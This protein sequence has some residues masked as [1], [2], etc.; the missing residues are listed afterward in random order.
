MI[1][2]LLD[3]DLIVFSHYEG[4]TNRTLGAKFYRI[5]DGALDRYREV[6]PINEYSEP[7][8]PK[9]ENPMIN[10]MRVH[11]H[12]ADDKWRPTKPS[13]TSVFRDPLM[14]ALMGVGRAPS[15]NFMDSQTVGD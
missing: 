1:R 6:F 4:A 3:Q 12:V 8:I 10:G 11:V 13:P 2:E 5:K 9:P 15:L 7:P 14:S